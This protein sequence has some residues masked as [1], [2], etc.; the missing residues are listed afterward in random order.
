MTKTKEV[1]MIMTAAYITSHDNRLCMCDDN[2]GQYNL[3][4]G[5][6]RTN[7]NKLPR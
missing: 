7:Q 3:C 6:Q 2:C 4:H 1:C 5:I